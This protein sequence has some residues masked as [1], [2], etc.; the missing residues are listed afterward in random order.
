MKYLLLLL[1]FKLSGQCMEDIPRYC[2]YSRMETLNFSTHSYQ[3]FYREDSADI[4]ILVQ[5]KRRLITFKDDANE[6]LRLYQ[7]DSCAVGNEITY[8]CRDVKNSEHCSFAFDD[9][10]CTLSYAEQK[11]KLRVI[12]R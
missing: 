2:L 6:Y 5:S 4:V 12:K 8:F 10:N 11:I 1:C 7:I 9:G 3:P